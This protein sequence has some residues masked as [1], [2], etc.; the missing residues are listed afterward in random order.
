MFKEVKERKK[1]GHGDFFGGVEQRLSISTD[2]A[3]G[4]KIKP[5][6]AGTSRCSKIV[7]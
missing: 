2:L 1:M 5:L 7:L 3:A 6:S 4:R